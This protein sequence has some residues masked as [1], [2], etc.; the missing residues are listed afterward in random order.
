MHKILN[1]G[2]LHQNVSYKTIQLFIVSMFWYKP[3]DSDGKA[4]D[5]K[6]FVS[7]EVYP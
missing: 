2:R 5:A 6:I 7:K 1:T 3:I 4:K